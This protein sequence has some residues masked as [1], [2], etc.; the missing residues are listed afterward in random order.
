MLSEL[1]IIVSVPLP[2]PSL[3]PSAADITANVSPVHTNESIVRRNI[4]IAICANGI[5][6]A[7]NRLGN[8]F[9]TEIGNFNLHFGSVCGVC[10]RVVLLIDPHWHHHPSTAHCS[11]QHNE[12]RRAITINEMLEKTLEHNVQNGTRRAR[13]I[14][15]LLPQ[16]NGFGLSWERSLCVMCHRTTNRILQMDIIQSR[17]R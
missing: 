17:C 1:L 16:N 6:C 12:T 14:D 10:V 9:C 15:L 2:V 4:I 11:V 3:P 8:D 13:R 7:L 5:V